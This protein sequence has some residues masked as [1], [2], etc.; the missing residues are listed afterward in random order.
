[1][2]KRERNDVGGKHGRV[3]CGEEVGMER[4]ERREMRARKMKY[5]E[6]K[7][8]PVGGDWSGGGNGG[9]QQW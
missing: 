6:N 2:F 9:R 3:W 1:M 8:W 7:M 5:V 4:K